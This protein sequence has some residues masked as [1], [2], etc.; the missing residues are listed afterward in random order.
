MATLASA[1]QLVTRGRNEAEEL[2][3]TSAGTI[4]TRLAYVFGEESGKGLVPLTEGIHGPLT[5][6]VAPEAASRPGGAR[7]RT[8]RAGSMLVAL[9]VLIS[10]YAL[11]VLLWRDPATDLY[12]KW[13]QHE[14][15]SA[16]AQEFRAYG[17][18]VPE[19]AVVREK[20]HGLP[21]VIRPLPATVASAR[22]FARSLEPGQPI[23]RIVIARLSLNAVVV[24]GTNWLHDL[25]QGPGRYPS[26]S[27][28]GLDRTTAIAG[29]RTTFGAWFRH[30]DR[31]RKHDTI[32]IVLPY[33]TFRY[34]VIGHKI[35]PAADWSIVRDRGY[36]TLV[37]SACH[38]LYS[39]S[40]RWVV[41]ARLRSVTPVRGRA[42]ALDWR[43]SKS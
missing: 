30:I 26:T 11:L 39:A 31:M 18:T 19:V 2:Y 4:G 6:T 42:Y 28:P 14:L 36:D 15:S 25:S 16:L 29:H 20:P 3:D 21:P 5:A 32:A 12:T 17:A 43:A 10:A 34:E 41:F 9:G 35:V 33:G 1:H 13:R 22:H 38:P 24:N 23:G 37:L 27:L 7:V 40:H 8:R